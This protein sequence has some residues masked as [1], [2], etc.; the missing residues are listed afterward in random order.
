[1]KTILLLLVALTS[2]SSIGQLPPANYPNSAEGLE[3]LMADLVSIAKQG[4]AASLNSHAQ[5][6]VLP[7][8]ESWFS[9]RFGNAHCSDSHMAITDCL[10]SRYAM[11]YN[12]IA[13]SLPDSLGLT[14]KDLI[15]EG[16]VNFEAV[17]YSEDC[18]GPARINPSLRLIGDLSTT[19][20][21]NVLGGRK[22]PIYVVW[23]YSATKETT[24]GFFVY[25]TGAFRYLGM[26]HEASIYEFRDK[27]YPLVPSAHNLTENE[28]EGNN[29]IVD[30]ATLQRKI[31]LKVSVDRNGKPLSVRFVRGA[32]EYREEAIAKVEKKSFAPPGFGPG[33]L[34][35]SEFCLQVIGG[36]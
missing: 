35:P 15:S 33:G 30:P 28:V 9:V 8:A 14:L 21:L 26:P 32:T 10:G 2:W 5:S 1:M 36:N 3:H 19:P 6:L 11:A 13:Q 18:A 20:F 12:Y 24:I 23:G 27:K 34:R 22:E 7:D 16:V 4:D 31:V 17:N 25:E 29:M